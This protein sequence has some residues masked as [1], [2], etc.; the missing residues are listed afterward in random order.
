MTNW[1]I[2]LYWSNDKW[3][4]AYNLFLTNNPLYILNKEIEYKVNGDDHGFNFNYRFGYYNDVDKRAILIVIYRSLKMNGSNWNLLS[5]DISMV[6]D[7]NILEKLTINSVIL[8]M[9]H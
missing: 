4:H 9:Y 6:N 8:N 3:N 7:L 5:T 2:A 1:D